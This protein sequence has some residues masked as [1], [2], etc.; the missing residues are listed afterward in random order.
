MTGLSSGTTYYVKVY[1]YAAGAGGTENYNVIS[2]LTGSQ[3]TS[4]TAAGGTLTFPISHH[5]GITQSGGVYPDAGDI[6]W[7]GPYDGWDVDR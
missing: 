6:I 5:T 4:G 3:A 7:A 2:P 1:A